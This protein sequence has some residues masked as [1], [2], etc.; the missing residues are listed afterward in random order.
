V[1]LSASGLPSGATASFN[2]ATVTAGAGST[3]TITTLAST[4][5]GT[6]TVT[7]TGTGASATHTT[8]VTLTVNPAGSGGTVVTNG[9]FETGSFTGWTTGGASESVVTGGHSGSDAA[10]LGSTAPTNGDSVMQQTVTVPANATLSFWYQAHCP[11][12]LTYDQEQMQVRSTSGTTLVNVLNVC[13]NP[14]TPTWVQK[15]ASLSGYAGQSVVLWFNSHDD[16]YPSDPTYTLF[17]DVAVT[18]GARPRP[19]PPAVSGPGSPL[20]GPGLVPAE[21]KWLRVAQ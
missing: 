5:A 16:N 12:T 20:I 15:T 17:D 11:D 2:P 8:A 7:V 1:S 3:L 10:R 21:S 13:Q 18:A 14:A 4:P 6:S 9:G 19:G